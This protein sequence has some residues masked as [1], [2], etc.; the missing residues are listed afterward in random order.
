MTETTYLAPEP[1]APPAIGKEHFSEN[2]AWRVKSLL[3][4]NAFVLLI[5]VAVC[6]CGLVSVRQLF[7]SPSVMNML[8][9]IL[10]LLLLV[11]PMVMIASAG[12][13]D[14]SI[15]A[16]A[17]L[18][19]IVM[20]TMLNEGFN[21]GLSFIIAML[22]ALAIG[23]INAGLVGLLRIHGALVT[24]AM[25]AVLGGLSR[26][27]TGGM[28]MVVRPGDKLGFLRKYVYESIPIWI[29]VVIFLLSCV[30]LVQ[31]TPL[32]RRRRPARQLEEPL[33]RRFVFTGLPY[34]LSSLMAGVA[35]ALWLGRVGAARST[36]D[37]GMEFG[38]IFAVVLGGLCLR[39]GFGSVVGSVLALMVLVIA[40]TIMLMQ[41][42]HWEVIQLITGAMLLL[43]LLLSQLYYLIVSAMYRPGVRTEPLP[44]P[45]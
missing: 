2:S 1:L 18:V 45:R 12:G 41:G 37:F 23:L 14:L 17:A 4:W 40:Q 11:A 36:Q 44:I 8:A 27:F 26:L 22:P 35:G 25:A 16:T 39:G 7:S 15:G 38:I 30:A 34:V 29:V 21:V 10:P 42:L 13:L 20:A 3:V 6:A 5:L 33:G 43:A 24:I 28:T 31:L 9:R 19:A 32:G